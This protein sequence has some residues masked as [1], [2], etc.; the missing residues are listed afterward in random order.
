MHFTKAGNSSI[1]FHLNAVISTVDLLKSKGY[2]DRILVVKSA[3]LP[4]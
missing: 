2:I 4:L 3:S 1:C